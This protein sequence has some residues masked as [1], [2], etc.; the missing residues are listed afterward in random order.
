MKNFDTKIN[1]EL[2]NKVFK[3]TVYVIVEIG[4]RSTE[5]L[6][7]NSGIRAGVARQR[8]ETVG[9]L[10]TA[11]ELWDRLEELFTETSLPSKLFLL[12]KFFRYKLDLSKNI[13]ENIDEFT[14]L[15][16]D[17][18]LTGDKNI[19]DYTPIV[20]LNAIPETYSDVKAAIKYGR[21]NG[22][23]KNR[24]SDYKYRKGGRSISRSK[25]RSKSRG[26]D[27]RFRDDK[28]RERRCY[29]CGG[30]GHYIKDC[31]K[32]KRDNR[33]NSKNDSEDANFISDN[34]GEVYMISDINNVQSSVNMHEWLIDSG[35]SFHMSPYKEIFS[36]YKTDDFGFVAMANEKLCGIKGL[37]DVCVTFDNGYKL[38]LKNVRHVPDLCHNLMSCSALE[39]EGLED[40]KASLWHRRLGH[41]SLKGLDLLHKDGLLPDKF[42]D[43]NF[44]DDCVLGKQH[45]VHFPASPYPNSPTSNDILDYVHADVWVLL[46][47]K[48]MGE[49]V[50]SVYFDNMS[51]KVFVFL[52]KQKA[53]VF[54]KFKQWKIFVE[55]Q[56]GRKLKVLRTDNGL[57]FCN[58]NFTELCNEFGI[59]RHKTNPYTPQQNGVAERM[60]RTLLNKVRCL[61]ISSGLPKSFWGEALLT[62][63]YLVNRS[64]SVPLLGKTPE[65]VW[66]QSD[67]DL[68]SLRIFGICINQWW[69][70]TMRITNRGKG[71]ENRNIEAGRTNRN[72]EHTDNYSLARNRERREH[73][74]PSRFRDFHLALN[75]EDSEPTSYDDAIKSPKSEFWIK[76]MKEEMKSLK[77]NKTW[78]LVP[79]PKNTSIVDSK[80]IF[81]LKNENDSLRYKARLVAKGFTQKEDENIYMAQ[82]CGFIDNRNSEH[83]PYSNAI[84]SVM[85]LMVCTRPDIAYAVSCLS[86]YMSNAGPPHWEALKWLLRYL[87]GSANTEY[88]ATTEAFKEAIWL[89]GLLKEIGFMKTRTKHIDVDTFIRDIVGKGII[90]LAKIDSESNPADMGTGMSYLAAWSLG[91]I[92]GELYSVVEQSV[93]GF[94]PYHGCV[95]QFFGSGHSEPF[96]TVTE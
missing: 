81:K 43:L 62:A 28:Y 38:T 17:I 69:R 4:N 6:T 92:L 18:K 5:G 70:K 87:S 63:A 72:P 20:L 29:N 31:R 21:D 39:E 58:Q 59:K 33:N 8:C 52:M 22:R 44:C 42:K 85:Y 47:L 65:C 83:V 82:P 95:T 51:R 73:R 64:P 23:T 60:N 88:I 9:K 14:K 49:Q 68:S 84:G 96:S 12:E 80:W 45:K 35:C 57:E 55:N 24:N 74:I 32:P 36:N 7:P 50:F 2:I 86:R 46:M 11:K 19:D 79:K 91:V 78:V 13:D 61:L 37:G 75:S 48:H 53:E 34:N 25:S 56:T 1:V 30:K 76:A 94:Q 89:E 10:E 54:E 71:L 26:R 40:D 15:V 27:E 90:L 93:L 3:P 67:I 41:I 16:Q 77:D 66:S